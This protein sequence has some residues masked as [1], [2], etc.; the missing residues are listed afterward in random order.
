M[1]TVDNFRFVR[2][3]LKVN[4]D[5]VLVKIGISKLRLKIRCDNEY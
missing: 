5:T 4:E 1:A 3:N 2:D